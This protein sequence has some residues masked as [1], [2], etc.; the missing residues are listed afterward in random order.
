MNFNKLIFSPKGNNW[1]NLDLL[2]AVTMFG[3]ESNLPLMMPV[4]VKR[5]DFTEN[6]LENVDGIVTV[7][8]Y[9]PN[10][11]TGNGNHY[12]SKLYRR[13]VFLTDAEGVRQDRTVKEV[14]FFDYAKLQKVFDF[15]REMGSITFL[16]E[17]IAFARKFWESIDRFGRGFKHNL[18]IGHEGGR[19][20]SRTPPS[21]DDKLVTYVVIYPLKHAIPVFNNRKADGVAVNIGLY[22]KKHSEQNNSLLW[23]EEISFALNNHRENLLV[24]DGCK[25]R[26]GSWIGGMYKEHLMNVFKEEQKRQEK[27]PKESKKEEAK[28]SS[29]KKISELYNY[30]SYSTTYFTS[31][32]NTTSNGT[33]S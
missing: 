26:D 17:N 22:W 6:K 30:T 11:R 7:M 33:W 1:G 14:E 13:N 3:H 31:T 4:V 19:I 10:P 2:P 21:W 25:I 32:S 29:N 12:V 18:F 5:E 23:C 27:K 8:N 15:A 24:V 28:K 20:G 16:L 9:F